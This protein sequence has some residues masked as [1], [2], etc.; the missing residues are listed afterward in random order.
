MAGS[1]VLNMRIGKL[2]KRITIQRLQTVVTGARIQETWSDVVSRWAHFDNLQSSR[3]VIRYMSEIERGMRIL[4]GRKIF[5]IEDISDI[6]ERS[7]E[8]HLTVKEVDMSRFDVPVQ[9]YR[10][11]EKKRQYNL[12]SAKKDLA[13]TVMGRPIFTDP[14]QSDADG[15]PVEFKVAKKVELP[16]D[17]DIRIGEEI[18][19]G[20]R[21]YLVKDVVSCRHW[22]SV[23]FEAE[24]TG[25][26]RY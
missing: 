22:L 8:I 5:D 12:V 4:Y 21:Q 24:V 11:M 23:S 19:I 18:H 14:I 25:H 26:D 10:V 9:I 13:A 3:V 16:L 20:G 6:E 1:G 7:K 17:T 2:N 15:K